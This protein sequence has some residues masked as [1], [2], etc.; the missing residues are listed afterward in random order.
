[1]RDQA[2]GVPFVHVSEGVLLR[3][4]WLGRRHGNAQAASCLFSRPGV[5]LQ[6]LIIRFQISDFRFRFQTLQISD[7]KNMFQI[8][9]SDVRFKWQIT[10]ADVRFQIQ[11]SDLRLHISDP[12]TQ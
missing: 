6:R 4:S 11:I 10:D 5:G 9:I 1:M 8:R 7:F 3:S 12:Q 2:V